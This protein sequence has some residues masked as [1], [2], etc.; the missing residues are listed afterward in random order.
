M[1][2]MTVDQIEA[3]RVKIRENAGE[4]IEEA[5]LLFQHERYARSYCLA[6]LAIEELAKIPM[7]VTAGVKLAAGESVNWNKLGKRLS[8]HRRKINMIHIENYMAS[9]FQLDNG[10]LTKLISDR[11]ELTPKLNAT[12]NASLYA[13]FWGDSF[14]KP[15]EIFNR[16]LA[17]KR[18]TDA[19]ELY[20]EREEHESLTA[21]VI[22]HAGTKWRKVDKVLSALFR[23][24]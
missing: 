17:Q 24:D 10:D 8:D 7:I 15:S 13:D 11:E 16:D 18:I 2:S 23:R 12:K 20:A 9:D 4:L 1:K 22:A 3:A 21:G 19:K 6:H 14:E 5:K